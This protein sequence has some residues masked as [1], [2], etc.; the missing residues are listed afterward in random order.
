MH[1]KNK[2]C[3]VGLLIVIVLMLSA[4]QAEKIIET[5]VVTE[6][7]MR[8][9]TPEVIENYSRRV[10]VGRIG[11]ADECAG[12]VVFLA[13]DGASYVNGASILIDGGLAVNGEVGHRN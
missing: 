1:A 8:E 11:R 2:F 3:L 12:A 7:V 9:G 6:I 10:P 13:S 4:C 5:V